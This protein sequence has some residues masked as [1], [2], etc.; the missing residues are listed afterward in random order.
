MRVGRAGRQ[1]LRR[2]AVATA[3]AL[4]GVGLT[5]PAAFGQSP[6]SYHPPNLVVL[7]DSFASGV[8]NTPYI[9]ESGKC[10]RSNSAYGPLLASFHVVTLQA[11]VACSGATTT[12]VLGTGPNGTEAPQIDSIAR[13]TDVVTVQALGNDF[14]VGEILFICLTT[15]CAPSTVL[16]DGHTVQQTI[17]S[18]PALGKVRLDALYGSIK[19][20]MEDVGSDARVI[21]TD[22]PSLFGQGGGICTGI[23]SP[24]ELGVAQQFVDYLNRAIKDAAQRN[25]FRLAAVSSLFKRHDVCG[26]SPAIYLPLPPG[27]FPASSDP[28]GGGVLHPNRFGQALYAAAIGRQL[29]F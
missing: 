4:V 22:Y 1:V 2:I 18:I 27:R 14:F 29:L 26:S 28:D 17:D 5:S 21:V 8:G 3:L 13:D 6:R 10:K 25:G 12:Q 15:E 16:K 11:F 9:V 24:T 7:G 19:E 23:I 20:K